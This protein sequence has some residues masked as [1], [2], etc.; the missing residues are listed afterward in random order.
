MITSYYGYDSGRLST[1]FKSVYSDLIK[2]GDI[3]LVLSNDMK[4]DLLKLGFP[5]DR[6]KLH[7]LGVKIDE[8]KSSHENMD[9]IRFL[10]VSRFYRGKGLLD[11]VNA[12]HRISLR[13]ENV[14]LTMVGNGPTGKRNQHNTNTIE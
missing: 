2:Y 6:I 7:H 3:F 10:V 4:S 13:Y 11:I 14:S 5:E 9:K 1:K 12:F 8:F